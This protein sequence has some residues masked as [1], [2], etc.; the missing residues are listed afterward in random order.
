MRTHGSR[1]IGQ[2]LLVIAIALAVACA[3]GTKKMTTL[4][5]EGNAGS[6]NE[7]PTTVVLFKVVVMEDGKPMP[8]VLSTVPR[9][10]WHYRVNVGGTNQPLDLNSAF[11][12]GQIDSNTGAIG[13]GFV[14]LPP[15]TYQLAFAAFRTRF[16]MPGARRGA[17]GHG[18]SSASRVEVPADANLLYIGT[19]AFDCH[20]ADRWWGYV[21]RECTQLQVSNEEELAQDVAST[22]LSRFGALQTVLASTAPADSSR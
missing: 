2:S 10:K 1:V 12:A 15:G 11:A 6:G 21:E 3:D 16:A 18:Q 19:F 17:L 20:K 22:F 4:P 14:T 13:W 8:G 5:K 7:A 9:W